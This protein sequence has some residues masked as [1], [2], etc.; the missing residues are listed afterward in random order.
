VDGLVSKTDRRGASPWRRANFPR[1][2]QKQSRRPITDRL[3][4]DTVREDHFPQVT[5]VRAAL[6]HSKAAGDRP[7][8]H[9]RRSSRSSDGACLKSTR[10][11]SGTAGLC[12]F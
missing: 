7:A 3:R 8:A 5:R 9:F 6:D 11:R 1:V 10:A 12:H 2:A 4:R